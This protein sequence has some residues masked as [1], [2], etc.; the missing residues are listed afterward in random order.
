MKENIIIEGGVR[1][2][3]IRVDSV[4]SMENILTVDVSTSGDFSIYTL[5]LIDPSISSGPPNGFDPILSEVSFSFKED[6]ASDFD[7]KADVFCP[8]ERLQEPYIDY[9]ARDYA[10]LRQLMLDRLNMLMPDWKER[11]PAD[12]MVALVE[13][14][15]YFGD[16]LSYFQDAVATEA[17]LGKAHKRISVRRH[18]RLLDYPMHDGCNARAWVQV[19]LDKASCPTSLLLEKGT[20]FMTRLEG[21]DYVIDPS[22]KFTIKLC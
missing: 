10:S 4:N 19:L 12:M 16:H 18:A 1:I 22:T 17:Y 14:L 21:F 5:R 9:L 20:Q 6:C 13:I 15:A 7:C 8:Q 11:N 2:K 3:D